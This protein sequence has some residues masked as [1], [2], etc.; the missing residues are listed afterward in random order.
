[1]V[2]I[3]DFD[4]IVQI[5]DLYH[6]KLVHLK[7]FLQTPIPC[8]IIIHKSNDIPIRR[9]ANSTPPIPTPKEPPSQT[10]P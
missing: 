4:E 10:S 6:S 3:D 7:H 8:P 2:I 1:M 5:M 9:H